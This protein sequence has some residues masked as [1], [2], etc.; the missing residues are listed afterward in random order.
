MRYLSALALMLLLVGPAMGA[1]GPADNQPGPSPWQIGTHPAYNGR[2][3]GETISTAV[4]I[5][6]DV[7][8]LPFHD[9]G[10]TCD[11]VDDYNEV[12][13]STGSTSPDVVYSFTPTQDISVD[14][15]LCASG[16]DT[17][18]YVYEAPQGLIACDDDACPQGRSF[19]YGLALTGG[20]TYYIVIDGDHD[21]CGTYD[22]NLMRGQGCVL[23]CPAGALVE[24]EPPC[25]DDYEDVFNG[26]CG[27]SNLIWSQ[28]EAGPDGCATVCGKSCNYLYEGYLWHDSDWYEAFAAGGPATVTC[29]AEFPIVII[30]DQSTSCAVSPEGAYGEAVPCVPAEVSHPY[31]QPGQR[32]WV[33]VSPIVDHVFPESDYVFTICGLAAM[34][35]PVEETSWGRIKNRYR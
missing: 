15:D 20:V 8:L 19:I 21:A 12:C 14:V 25:G 17:K 11:N 35:T 31:L 13:G 34:P 24:G 32:V 18:V 2:D 1:P 29:K 30:L 16:Y 28:I 22:L 27:S 9:T 5:P 7:N 33:Y 10:N 3:G 6:G 4:V 26:G 23:E